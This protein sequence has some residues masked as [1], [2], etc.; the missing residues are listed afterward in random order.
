LF[1]WREFFG[2][3][4]AFA[5]LGLPRRPYLDEEQLTASYLTLAKSLHPD[6]PGGDADKFAGAKKAFELLK[7][8]SRRLRHLI[9]LETGQ[10]PKQ[11]APTIAAAL[12]TDVCAATEAARVVI[13]K[14]AALKSPLARALVVGE[15]GKAISVTES[16]MGTVARAG[17]DLLEK[18]HCLD[19]EWP[20]YSEAVSLAADLRFLSKC[21]HQLEES[22]FEL[23]QAMRSQGERT[24]R[25]LN[26]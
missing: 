9:E 8:P 15:L 18:L 3:T 11:V 13:A 16:I 7:D 14:A 5:L 6:S 24:S 23:T 21:R 19:S 22:H 10:P 20:K 26:N 25:P 4:D 1:L 2:V 12:F 17:K